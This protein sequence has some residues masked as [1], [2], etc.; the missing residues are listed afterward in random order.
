[1]TYYS[2]I[3]WFMI[4]YVRIYTKECT[5]NENVQFNAVS[6][7]LNSSNLVDHNVEMSSV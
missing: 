5:M 6:I 3:V 2:C 4:V 7:V 1:M